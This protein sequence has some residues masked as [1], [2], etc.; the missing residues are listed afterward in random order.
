MLH[1]T[2]YKHN[3]S[4]LMLPLANH[5]KLWYLAWRLRRKFHSLALFTKGWELPFESKIC[6][7]EKKNPN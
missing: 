4:G 7:Q 1:K 2:L 5:N 6:K 3:N